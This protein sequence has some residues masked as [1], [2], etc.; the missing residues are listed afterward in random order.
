MPLQPKRVLVACLA[1]A[2]IA[3]CGD[4]SDN[5]TSGGA[6]ATTS[7]APAPDLGAIKTYLTDHTAQ[8]ALLDRVVL[9]QLLCTE[10]DLRHR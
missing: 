6:T 9:D 1:V 3:G 2:A 4:D 5:S 10:N 7:A 8:H